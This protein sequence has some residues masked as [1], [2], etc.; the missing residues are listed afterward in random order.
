MFGIGIPEFMVLI[1]IVVL[2]GIPIWIWGRVAAKAGSS[3]ARGLAAIVPVVNVVV[4][5]VFAFVHRPSVDGP[6]QSPCA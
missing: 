1:V 3:R 6:P 2:V 4:A 5:W